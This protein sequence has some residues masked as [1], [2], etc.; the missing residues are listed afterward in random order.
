MPFDFAV[1]GSLALILGVKHAFDADHLVAVSSLL[2]RQKRLESSF[3]LAGSWALGHLLTAALVSAGLYW[4]ADTML[5]GLLSRLELLVP[6]MLLVVGLLGLAMEA[7]RFHVHR[8]AHKNGGPEH[9]HLHLHLKPHHEHGAMAGIGFVH[10]LASN[11]EL[12]VVLLI[13]L[14]AQAWWQ[15]GLG[16]FLFSLGVVLGM[17]LYA[18]AVHLVSRRSGIRWVP[19]ALTVL[20]SLASV[21]Y[22]VYLLMGG[23]SLNLLALAD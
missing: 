9:R 2:T 8:H 19:A 20:F 15:V 4:L 23:S 10:G 17:I 5:P 22:A 21:A 6:L 1:F 18:A 3:A 16:V 14:G 12:I 11:D 13:G 7:R